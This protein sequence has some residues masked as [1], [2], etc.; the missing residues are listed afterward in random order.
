MTPKNG[1][2]SVINAAGESGEIAGERYRPGVIS[3]SSMCR[4]ADDEEPE[5]HHVWNKLPKGMKLP[6]M[7]FEG[8][9]PNY[10]LCPPVR[11]PLKI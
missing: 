5:K 7:Q 3:E 11:Y 4:P 8:P 6:Q 2:I 10:A 1:E 9:P